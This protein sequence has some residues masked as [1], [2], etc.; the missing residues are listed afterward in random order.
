MLPIQSARAPAAIVT[1]QT[2][3]SNAVTAMPT[4]KTAIREK[5]APSALRWDGAR[6]AA[7]VDRVRFDP[8][9]P[10][11]VAA[12]VRAVRTLAL[13]A[14]VAAVVIAY[15][16]YEDGV[17]GPDVLVIALFL[18]PPV[19]LWVLWAALRELVGLP[20]R[21]RRL[22]ETARGHREDVKR[23]AEELRTPGRR[24]LGVPVTL[25]R[26]RGAVE[27]VRPHAAV[28]PFLSVP[29]LTAAALASVAALVEIAIA[30]VLL[31]AAAT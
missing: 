10:N 22:P 2:S 21:L 18:A 31:I 15:A 26:L 8:P 27:L 25:W 13:L 30:L 19:V 4:K 1:T 9:V 12:F 28:L 16:L 24:L 6:I 11:V 14:S 23:L 17:T 3:A 7:S 29:F 20:E 5:S